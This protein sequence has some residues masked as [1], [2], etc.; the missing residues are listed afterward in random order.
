MIFKILAL[1]LDNSILFQTLNKLI[2]ASYKQ[3]DT[4][5][6][7]KGSIYLSLDT[8]LKMILFFFFF[9]ARVMEK[10]L[11]TTK[12]SKLVSR[13]RVLIFILVR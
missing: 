7:F 4:D 9:Y 11:I 12:R 2:L 8:L 1:A 5:F 13:R 10:M 6:M 3:E